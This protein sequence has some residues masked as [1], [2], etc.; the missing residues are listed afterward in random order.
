M[1]LCA[2]FGDTPRSMAARLRLKPVDMQ[3]RMESDAWTKQDGLILA[4]LE[5]AVDLQKGGVVPTLGILPPQ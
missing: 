4:L 1:L 5:Q 2:K 3:R